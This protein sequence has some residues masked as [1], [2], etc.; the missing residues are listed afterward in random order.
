MQLTPAALRLRKERWVIIKLLEF[1]DLWI[2]FV[3]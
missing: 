1:D 3:A 2:F